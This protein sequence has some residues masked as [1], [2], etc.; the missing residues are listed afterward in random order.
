MTRASHRFE[1]LD[2][3]RGIAA[4]AVLLFHCGST[5][6]EPRM[7]GHGALAVDVFFVMS[8]FVVDRAYGARLR[9]GWPRRA[10]AAAR[11]AR[12]YP[13]YAAGLLL[14][15]ALQIVQFAL[16]GRTVPVGALVFVMLAGALLAPLIGGD[17]QQVFPLNGPAWSL[18]TEALMNVAFGLKPL[19]GPRLLGTAV[20]CAALGLVLAAIDGVSLLQ[21]GRSD[22]LW[23]DI[24]RG[25]FGFGAGVLISKAVG[26]WGMPMLRGRWATAAAV[27]ILG[28]MLLPRTR[29]DLWFDPLAILLLC[30]ATILLGT[31][32]SPSTGAVRRLCARL[33]ALSYPL[34]IVHA[35]LLKLAAEVT[36]PTSGRLASPRALA[37]SGAAALGL[38]L[39]GVI[40]RWVEPRLPRRLAQGRDAGRPAAPVWPAAALAPPA[41][42]AEADHG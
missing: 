15:A 41:G 10:F 7:M 20:G 30:P 4:I 38:V 26:R 11:A 25:V 32:H 17:E 28:T 24:L 35:P 42:T 39:A 16:Q 31:A 12:L 40:A 13:L 9:A 33:G 3:I 29:A 34:Y 21:G 23:V 8:G 27:A 1:T 19:W 5:L 14:G 37:V 18:M 6:D 22:H 36:P 2:G